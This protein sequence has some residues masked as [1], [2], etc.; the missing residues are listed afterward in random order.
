M[1]VSSQ[2]GINRV[3]RLVRQAM[4]IAW[5]FWRSPPMSLVTSR[6]RGGHLLGGVVEALL[7]VAVVRA[8][9]V[10]GHVLRE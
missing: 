4:S 7:D 9:Q 6:D 5:I 8:A 10:T 1:T 2:I 3:V